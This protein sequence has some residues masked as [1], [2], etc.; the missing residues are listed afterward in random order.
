V[1]SKKSSEVRLSGLGLTDLA[2]NP[3]DSNGSAGDGTI[4]FSTIADVVAPHVI[5]TN[6]LVENAGNVGSSFDFDVWFKF[7]EEL[8][9]S[10][11][12][13]LASLVEVGSP[14]PIAIAAPRWDTD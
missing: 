9:T 6:S 5:G 10:T 1:A 8:D 12:V 3:L 7:S 13:G 2:G 4:A 11:T 14:T